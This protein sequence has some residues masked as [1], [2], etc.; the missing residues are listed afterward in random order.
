MFLQMKIKFM[1][2]VKNYSLILQHTWLVVIM[3]LVVPALIVILPHIP[4]E[5]L[6]LQSLEDLRRIIM[7]LP[8]LQVLRKPAIMKIIVIQSMRIQ[9]LLQIAE[10]FDT[11][12]DVLVRMFRTVDKN[13]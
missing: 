10:I 13:I 2:K 8:H 11:G 6:A 9:I 12:V 4:V 5:M 3:C 7:D 1:S